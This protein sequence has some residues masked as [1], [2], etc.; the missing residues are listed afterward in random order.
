MYEGERFGPYVLREKIAQGGMAEIYFGE[1]RGAHDFRRE[2][3]IKRIR[4]NLCGD[5]SF[6]EMFIDEARICSRL[7]HSNIVAIDDFG[8]TDGQLYICMEWVHGTDVGRLLKRLAAE[9]RRMPVDAALFVLSEVLR[10]LEYA[11]GKHD[12]GVAL[13]IVHRDVT[14]HNILVS[15]AGEVKL[16]DFGIA[17]ATSR[18]H[19]TQGDLVKGKL[20]YMAP[21]QATGKALDGRTDLFALGICAFEILTG[22]RPFLGKDREV[23]LTMLR[24]ERAALRT[25]RPDIPAAVEKWV[26]TLLRLPMDQRFPTAAAALDAMQAIPFATGARSL[27]ALLSEFYPDQASVVTPAV[28]G[29]PPAPAV[30][31]D[32][33]RPQRPVAAVTAVLPAVDAVEE[34]TDETAI[35]PPPVFTPLPPPIA[36]TAT[37]APVAYTPPS[38]A[39]TPAA[40][41]PPPRWA[42]RLA[43]PVALTALAV[44][45]VT[46]ALALQS[47]PAAVQPSPAPV[48]ASPTPMHASPTPMQVPTAPVQV[49]A[50]PVQAPAASAPVEVAPASVTVTVQPW[51]GA[52]LDGRS[53]PT[54]RSVRVP[55]GVHTVAASQPGGRSTSRRITLAPGESARV[56]LEIPR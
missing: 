42:R 38:A 10:G 52:T 46:A 24:G 55:A 32:S 6:V 44:L 17:K 56:R 1:R 2:V 50:A 35:T 29:A 26:D 20:A 23:I 48:H 27:T 8:N 53:I 33:T 37:S 39:A 40:A 18:L 43:L 54:G 16:S 31:L 49:P 7:R 41:S 21:E 3:C 34:S 14:P 11:H 5:P 15:Y 45:G 28:G 9:G 51:G 13:D 19:Q 25:L 30:A 12:Q 4:P 36:P 47:P 22:Q